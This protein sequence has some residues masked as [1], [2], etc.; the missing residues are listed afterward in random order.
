[1]ESKLS[2]AL[3]EEKRIKAWFD[4]AK[5]PNV[6]R[7][8]GTYVVRADK[9]TLKVVIQRLDADQNRKTVESF[10]V[11]GSA[12]DLEGLAASVRTELETRVLALEAAKTSPK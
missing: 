2:D 1:L 8:A 3:R 6:Y 5:H 7:V 9:V 4:I 10:E 12:K 11:S